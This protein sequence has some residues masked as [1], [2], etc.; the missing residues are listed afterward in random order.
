MV[1]LMLEEKRQ[2]LELEKLWTLG[3]RFDDQMRALMQGPD[4]SV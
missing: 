2:S 3:A 1:H 4:G